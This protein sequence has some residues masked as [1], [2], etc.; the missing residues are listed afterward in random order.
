[1]RAYMGMHILECMHILG[2]KISFLINLIF[3]C[4]LDFLVFYKKKKKVLLGNI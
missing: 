4:L 1:M 3:M 2:Y